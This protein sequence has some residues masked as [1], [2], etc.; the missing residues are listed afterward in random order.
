FW[1]RW[2]SKLSL[3]LQRSI[4]NPSIA[5]LGQAVLAL[6]QSCQPW[7]VFPQ[8]KPD[9][10]LERLARGSRHLFSNLIAQFGWAHG[11]IRGKQQR[12]DL[13]HI[14]TALGCARKAGLRFRLGL[15][16]DFRSGDRYGSGRD[17]WCHQ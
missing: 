3:R 10:P 13:F 4:R 1:Q 7:F 5:P 16:S 6:T 14:V 8:L 17:R 15:R 2:E 9:R 12:D 11:T